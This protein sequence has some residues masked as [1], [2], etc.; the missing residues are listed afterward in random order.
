MPGALKSSESRL[1]RATGVI[2]RLAS[3]E[4]IH[5]V[6]RFALVS[7]AGLGLDMSLFAGLVALGLRA[8][9]ANVV[10]A[11]AA[12]AFVYFTSTRRVF[13]Y[14]GQF[15][16]QLFVVYVGYQVV[17]V[18]LA[19][20]AVDALVRFGTRPLLAKVMILPATFSA[21]YLFMS[22]LTKPRK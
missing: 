8:G 2:D 3:T 19:S 18:S 21:N 13:A 5:R 16:L 11:G 15:L 4:L 12:V 6:F 22:F 9:F 14:R 1:G 20:W 10:S 17:A 7:G